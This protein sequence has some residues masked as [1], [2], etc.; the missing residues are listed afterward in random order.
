MPVIPLMGF[1]YRTN[2]NASYFTCINV[3]LDK[4]QWLFGM[5]LSREAY[6]AYHILQH[7]MPHSST[8][9]NRGCQLSSHQPLGTSTSFQS[10]GCRWHLGS[11]QPRGLRML[12]SKVKGLA[13]HYAQTMHS[14]P[15]EKHT[16]AS[17]EGLFV[18]TVLGYWN[19]GSH[20]WSMDN[21][22]AWWPGFRTPWKT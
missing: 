12:L 19:V 22:T 17:L 15:L 6:Q 8:M 4:W 1:L 11:A 5:G 21:R 3:W 14:T 16:K 9:F 18:R 20:S 2:H 7:F 10:C 13:V